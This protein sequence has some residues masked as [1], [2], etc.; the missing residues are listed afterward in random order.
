MKK[1]RDKIGR[2][3]TTERGTAKSHANL[4][5]E[6]RAGNENDLFEILD[7]TDRPFLLILDLVT[8]PHNLG[9]CLRSANAVGVHAVVV[10]KNR[11]ASLTETARHIASGAAEHTPFIQVTNLARTM[12]LL[13]EAGV[14]IVGTSHKARKTLYE[15]DMSG[16]VALTL[17]SEGKGLRRLTEEQC[18]FLV[19]IPMNGQVEC[20]NVSVAT[21]V[22]LYEALRQR[23]AKE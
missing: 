9:A 10:P 2:R 15:V 12:R 19:R 3:F 17:G 18:D 16:S 21:G 20:L 5:H 8:D 7:K 23:S 11:A 1:K 4:S 22:C 6:A 14:W 13:K